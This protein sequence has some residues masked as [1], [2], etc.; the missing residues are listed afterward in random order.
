MIKM[1]IPFNI[2]YTAGKECE[3]IKKVIH[4]HK[5]CGDG[6]FTR[7]CCELLSGKTKAEKILLTSSC[8]HSLEMSAILADIKEGDEVIMPSFTFVSTANAFVLRGA[9]IV[10]VDIRPDTLNIDE[11]KIEEAISKRTKAIVPVHYAGVSCEMAKIIE[12]AK[13]YNLFVIEDSAQALFSEYNN[14]PLGTIGDIGCISFHE[15]KNYHCGEGGAILINRVDLIERAEIIREKGTNRTKFLRGQVDKYSWV[16]VGSSY[17]MSDINAAFLFAQLEEYKD[18]NSKRE[19]IWQRYYNNLLQ[20]SYEGSI[21][22]PS[23]PKGCLQNH[24]L[25]Y[26]KL[27]NI[28]ERQMLIEYLKGFN[29]QSVFHYIP[30]HS[31]IA[32]RQFGIF[33][34]E[35]R[36]TTLESERL[37]RLPLYNTIN[38]NEIDFVCD[39]VKSY[40]NE[41]HT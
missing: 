24:H 32:G 39:K 31:S 22:L 27:K 19:S 37:L 26:I 13:E 3:Y 40:F 15:T 20:L 18:I 4:S 21:E 23:I 8:T 7:K 17:L 35:D 33:H 36:Y 11:T 25:F 9:R 28:N 2:P 29:I 41:N 16:D 38:L 1:D 34:G 30:L 12:I 6:Q 5:F 14:R 10:F